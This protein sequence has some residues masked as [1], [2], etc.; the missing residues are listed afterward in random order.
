M[1][2]W[3]TVEKELPRIDEWYLVRCPEYSESGFEIAQ[4][5]GEEWQHGYIRQSCHE[6]VTGYCAIPLDEM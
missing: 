3:K 5:D 4:W 6:Y 2:N 1:I